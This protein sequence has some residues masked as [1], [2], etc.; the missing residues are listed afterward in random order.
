MIWHIITLGTYN[1][2]LS[3]VVYQRVAGK[4]RQQ[5]LYPNENSRILIIAHS[6]S[7]MYF[8]LY[9]LTLAKITI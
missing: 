7:F 3:I 4:N 6:L 1:V 9:V 8:V 5:L 2:F